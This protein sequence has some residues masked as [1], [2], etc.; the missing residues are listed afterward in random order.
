MN[1]PN[2]MA[3]TQPNAILNNEKTDRNCK[4]LTCRKI[5]VDFKT[6]ITHQKQYIV[7]K[8]L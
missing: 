1:A 3:T 5:F 2:F 4:I 8:L 6:S 7:K